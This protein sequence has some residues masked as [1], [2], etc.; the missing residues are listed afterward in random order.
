MRFL[1]RISTK[2]KIIIPILLGLVLVMSFCAFYQVNAQTATTE[3]SGRSDISTGVL[4]ILSWPILFFISVLA[5]LLTVIIRLLVWVAQYNDFINSPAVSKGWIII[6]DICN[7]SFILALLIIAFCTVL[8]IENYSYK[9][10]LG[11]LVLAAVLV[12][13][14][15]LICGFLIDISQIIMLTFVN[16][17]K[18]AAE[19]NFAEMLGLT[20][21]MSFKDSITGADING[22]EVFGA[23][24]L[25][26]IMVGVALLVIG[27]MAV[28]LVMRIVTLWFL[29]LLSPLIFV[30]P[31]FPKGK[32]Y[33][34]DWWKKFSNELIVGPA[35]A[36]MLWL[37]LAVV[38]DQ[39]DTIY[40]TMVTSDQAAKIGQEALVGKSGGGNLQASISET[41]QPQYVLNFIIGIAMLVGSL[42][43]A[44]QLGVAGSQLA[45]K[46][47][48]D[49]QG[50]ASGAAKGIV[51]LPMKGVRGL[52][53]MAARKIESKVGIPIRPE[54]IKREIQGALARRRWRAEAE[55]VNKR[56][57]LAK[58]V[59]AKGWVPGLRDFAKDVFG[60]GGR[61][62]KKGQEMVDE[63]E[64]IK[65]THI[66]KSDFIKTK[67]DLFQKRKD[68]NNKLRFDAD[69]YPELRGLI[70]EEISPEIIRYGT[71]DYNSKD[72]EGAEVLNNLLVK[73]EEKKK[74]YIKNGD[75]KAEGDIDGEIINLKSAIN[76]GAQV[77]LESGQFKEIGALHKPDY[78]RAKKLEGER[79]LAKDFMESGNPVFLSQSS[80]PELN[81]LYA[82]SN[83]EW[84]KDLDA[85]NE[86]IN[87]LDKTIADKED[88]ILDDRTWDLNV[89]QA[90]QQGAEL[91]KAGRTIKEPLGSYERQ[92]AEAA[93]INEEIKLL[94]E[95]Y[96]QREA[97]SMSREYE[98]KEDWIKFK[99]VFAQMVKWGDVNETLL[100]DGEK[101]KK[102]F[103]TAK[104]EGWDNWA[105]HLSEKFKIPLED[106][107]RNLNEWCNMSQTSGL[108]RMLSPYTYDSAVKGLRLQTEDEYKEQY[109]YIK[110]QGDIETE[111][112][113]TSKMADVGEEVDIVTGRRRP[114][115]GDME[116]D[117]FIQCLKGWEAEIDRRYNKDKLYYTGSPKSIEFMLTRVLPKFATRS[118]PDEIDKFIV[119]IGKMQSQWKALGRQDPGG[120][121]DIPASSLAG[122][123]T[124]K[125]ID[126]IAKT[127]GIDLKKQGL[128]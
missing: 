20:K 88:H 68:H 47:I 35:M 121:I 14:S 98:E 10:L 57:G 53:D 77:D 17:F 110:G 52:A 113:K 65:R 72:K 32:G 13:F 3:T 128:V 74:E 102:D 39:G 1:R 115:F 101:Y 2:K 103:S 62:V 31:L 38:Q 36:F 105:Q 75:S 5:K 89:T 117:G 34:D 107:R 112:R 76:S 66:S 116:V 67:D 30:A 44:Q 15:K 97:I 23:L 18:A 59:E 21:I 80:F 6:R 51:G 70:A 96:D 78:D 108:K 104:P 25:G 94:P 106:V 61:K 49:M 118:T 29:I 91:M 8:K 48:K 95:T 56:A 79:K 100:A 99:A 50:F 27:I 19:G 83:P 16:A 60:V 41:G 122:R 43:V 9:K 33:A 86:S 84:A 120:R 64:K 123:L 7:M 124:Q 82:K 126:D 92:A 58:Q 114:V 127:V 37:S 4:Q 69:K 11:K 24:I 87:S 28:I 46:G 125:Q 111:T 109:L 42:M 90:Q 85:L 26:L 55:Y 73:A 22:Y 119:L 12:N 45:S 71:M 93:L 63:S 40:T 54:T 81:K